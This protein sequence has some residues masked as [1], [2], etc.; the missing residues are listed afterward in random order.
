MSLGAKICGLS[1]PETVEAAVAGGADFI[2]F[3]FFPRSPRA[4]TAAR[5]ADL[6][7][8]VP[9]RVQR[10][11]L[12][13]D[14]DDA[15]I[16]AVLETVPLDLLQLHGAE[17]PERCAAIR[18]RF[19]RPVMKAFG[20][21]SAEDAARAERW[22]GTVDRLLFDAKPPRLEGALPG[23]N[24]AAFDWRIL[25]GRSWPL[26][27]MLSGGLNAGNLAEAVRTTGA[28]AVDVSSGVETSPGIKDIALIREFLSV[29]KGL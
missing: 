8:P 13:V 18:E 17:T 3:V 1:T 10:C 2:G 7:R 20:I 28:P 22:V 6:A 12:F 25:A 23:G 4:V 29:A 27:W 15:T 24:G 5:A 19:R 9:R 21:A 26:P 16:E 11:G 14:A